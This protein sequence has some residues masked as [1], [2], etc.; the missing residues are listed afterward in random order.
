MS[1]GKG[2]MQQAI[3]HIAKPLQASLYEAGKSLT[4]FIVLISC[5]LLPLG[6]RAEESSITILADPWCPYN[7]EADSSK[8]GIGIEA[9]QKIFSAQGLK[10]KYINR[11][12]QQSLSEVRAGQYDA[13]IGAYRSDAPDFIFPQRPFAYSKTC[14]FICDDF[15]WEFEGPHSL[16]NIR[17]GVINGYSYGKSIDQYVKEHRNSD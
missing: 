12:W 8:P 2:F 14:F 9:A 5:T 1:I 10:V 17:L 7:C 15:N 13:V 4:R 6:L 16:S 11:D 3:A